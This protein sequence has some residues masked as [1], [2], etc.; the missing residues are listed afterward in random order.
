MAV[1]HTPG[2]WTT[3]PPR[4]P[5]YLAHAT[6]YDR[7]GQRWLYIGGNRGPSCF[8]ADLVISR[9]DEGTANAR[10]IA[11]A[12]DL[13]EA[14]KAALKEVIAMNAKLCDLHGVAHSTALIGL[15]LEDAI[16]KAEG[17]DQ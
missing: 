7:V 3:L 12:P 9:C 14:C 13:L 17:N 4:N 15:M 16:D 1:N 6:D 10:L 11:A 5:L 8:V 2:P